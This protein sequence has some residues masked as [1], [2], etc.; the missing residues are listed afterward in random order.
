M[1]R[2]FT[3]WWSRAAFTLSLEHAFRTAPMERWYPD[4]PSRRLGVS[5]AAQGALA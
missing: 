1:T 3:R 2:T 4:G 5:M